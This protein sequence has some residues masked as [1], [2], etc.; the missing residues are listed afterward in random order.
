MRDHKSPGGQDRPLDMQGSCSLLDNVPLTDK[1]R[2]PLT[3]VNVPGYELGR[4][5]NTVVLSPELIVRRSTAP[6][7]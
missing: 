2:P 3:T 7:G 4:L 6:P 1:I 5:A